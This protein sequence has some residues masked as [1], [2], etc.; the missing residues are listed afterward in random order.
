MHTNDY[1]KGYYISNEGIA[2]IT[3]TTNNFFTYAL[4]VLH[5]N[6]WLLIRLNVWPLGYYQKQLAKKNP[7]HFSMWKSEHGNEL[8]Y[9]KN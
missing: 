6:Q 9:V 8:T 1:S 4:R 2:Y 5:T 3:M 7:T